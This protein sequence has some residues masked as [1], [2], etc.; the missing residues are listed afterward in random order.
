MI[1]EKQKEATIVQE[2][3]EN[4]SIGMSLDL[5][6]AQILMQMLSKNLYSDSIG[7]TIR[8]CAS[9]ALDS[10]RRLG[11]TTP[12]IVGLNLNEQDNYEFTVEDFGT[13]LDADDVKNIISK[14]GK[15]TKRQEANALG[16]MGLG[17]KAPLA[18]SSSFYFVC[19]KNGM[20]RKY[21]MYEGED[22]NTIDLLYECET[23]ESNGVKIIVPVVFSDRQAFFNKIKTQLAYFENV[24][25]D[26]KLVSTGGYGYKDSTIENDFLI[27]RSKHFQF[28]ELSDDPRLHICL[29]NVYYP[30][31]FEKLGI[32]AIILPIG[33]RFSLSDGLYPTPNR[34]SLRYTSEAIATIKNKIQEV[35]D[36]YIEKYNSTIEET[37]D[38]KTIF[39]YYGSTNRYINQDGKDF[40]I[41]N[42]S[43]YS[44][45]S[46]KF[47]SFK[48]VTLLNLNTVYRHRD[49]ILNEYSVKYELGFRKMKEIKGYW[50][51]S[52][53]PFHVDKEH[54]L[55]YEDKLDNKTKSYLRDVLKETDT[56]KFIKKSKSFVL[57]PTSSKLEYNNYY[58]ILDLKKY[59]KESWRKVIKEFQLVLSGL[60]DMFIPVN[61][62]IIT[63]DWIDSKK[64]IK[65]AVTNSG[66]RKIK[67]KG[68]ISGK[69]A[70]DLQRYVNGKTCKFV[71]TTYKLEDIYKKKNLIIYGKHE[72]AIKLDPIYDISRAQKIIVSTFSDREIKVIESGEIHNLMPYNVFMEGKNKPFRRI[73]TA[74]LIRNLIEEHRYTFDKK[75]RLSKISTEL[76]N[77]LETL[78]K[79]SKDNYCNMNTD[80]FKAMLT[81]AEEHQY[82]DMQIY[83]EYL[84]MKAFFEKMYFLEPL[85][86]RVT[87]IDIDKD[88]LGFVICD[89]FKYYRFKLNYTRY[90]L[91]TV[92]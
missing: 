32:P 82:F 48:G 57:K 78:Q 38:I 15:S 4:E 44:T 75:D 91:P 8:E 64:K 83:P 58:T 37:T 14:Y 79:Y 61:Y 59:P 60:T 27:H 66:T 70:D 90:N 1:L 13:G 34:E 84:E 76:F 51:A 77:K 12:I 49:Y 63:Q 25:F 2:G 6:S 54:Y 29:D 47:P 50:S 10:H 85:M 52:L 80:V 74:C 35:A 69:Q 62:D 23:T 53:N 3:I 36:Y 46:F 67:L 89:L 20:E 24:Y 87:Q 40:D 33:L 88:P 21:M 43:L 81:V 45:I 42:L 28:S 71:P 86:Q 92:E 16:M 30:I 9:N 41:A 73:V 55:I 31:D 39:Q 7:S 56:Y 22:V 5:D 11:I 17:F 72:D 18:Y 65:L 26:V 19:R 68:E